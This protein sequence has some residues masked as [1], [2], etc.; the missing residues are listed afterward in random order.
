MNKLANSNVFRDASETINDISLETGLFTLNI[1]VSNI[2]A[3]NGM[4]PSLDVSLRYSSIN[5]KKSAYGNRF[6]ITLSKYD[7]TDK[8]LYLSNGEIYKLKF[9]SLG[10][11]EFEKPEPIDYKIS[12]S[13]NK[14]IL[15]IHKDGLIESFAS[16][17]NAYNTYYV[18]NITTPEG[19]VLSC[20][21]DYETFVNPVL[22][23]IR[24]DN[25][26]L[27]E[28]VRNNET[29]Q[30]IK[31]IDYANR[32]NRILEY[33]NNKLTAVILSE[34]PNQGWDMT[35]E[36]KENMRDWFLTEYSTPNG[37]ITTIVYDF[38]GILSPVS[39]TSNRVGTLDSKT[40]RVKTVTRRQIDTRKLLTK[41][42]TIDMSEE[43]YI[44]EN[45][46][47][48]FRKRKSVSS[49]FLGYNAIANPV[50]QNDDYAV[51]AKG[52]YT[53]SVI[54]LAKF[55][56][57]NPE[58]NSFDEIYITKDSYQ[59]NKFHCLIYIG[60][61]FI[62]L[63]DEKNIDPLTPVNYTSIDEVISYNIDEE[64][65]FSAQVKYYALP[66]KSITTWSSVKDSGEPS[67]RSVTTSTSY[68]DSGN[69]V[70]II[71]VDGAKTT[72]TYY[73]VAGEEGAC[74]PEPNGFV[75]FIKNKTDY[76]A[77][78]EHV[79]PTRKLVNTYLELPARS[80]GTIFGATKFIRKQSE[81]IISVEVPDKNYKKIYISY[82]SDIE[83]PFYGSISNITT[84]EAVTLDDVEKWKTVYTQTYSKQ[85]ISGPGQ[86]LEIETISGFTSADNL[87]VTIGEVH[88]AKSLLLLSSRDNQYNTIYYEYND[89]R[90][91]AIILNKGTEYENIQRITY[92]FG[93]K[94]SSSKLPA[95]RS[96]VT[97]TDAGGNIRRETFD[98]YQNKVLD[99]YAISPK[100]GETPVYNIISENLFTSGLLHRSSVK[101]YNQ[102]DNSVLSTIHQYYR[103]SDWGEIGEYISSQGVSEIYKHDKTTNVEYVQHVQNSY[104]DSF[105]PTKP[106]KSGRIVNQLDNIGNILFVYEFT[107]DD[108]FVSKKTYE[109][110]GLNRVRFYSDELTNENYFSY[111][112]FDRNTKMTR[113][114]SSVIEYEYQSLHTKPVKIFLKLN[115]NDANRMLIG[116][117]TLD[118]LGRVTSSTIGSRKYQYEFDEDSMPYPSTVIKPDGKNIK[119]TYDKHIDN[120]TLS[121]VGDEQT[122][123]TFTYNKTFGWL[124]DRTDH[125]SGLREEFTYNTQGQLTRS[126]L[127]G[128]IESTS[129]EKITNDYVYSLGGLLRE[130]IV[131]SSG[132]KIMKRTVD[133]DTRG[134]LSIFTDDALKSTITYDKLNRHKKVMTEPVVS[135][136][137]ELTTSQEY[138][139]DDF[140]N[141]TLTKFTKNLTENIATLTCTF[142][143]KKRLSTK[144][145]N[146]TDSTGT[147]NSSYTYHYD[148][149]DQLQQTDDNLLSTKT[150]WQYDVLGNI[151]DQTVT[152]ADGKPTSTAS[153]SYA[154][155]DRCQLSH[156]ATDGV[157][158]NLT[159]DSN[160]CLLS[161]G[162]GNT[163]EYDILDRCVKNND[164][165]TKYDAEDKI[166]GNDILFANYQN[167]E[168]T[169]EVQA[170]FLSDKAA[171]SYSMIGHTSQAFHLVV[172][173]RIILSERLM[174]D[175][176]ATVFATMN[177]EAV[178]SILYSSWGSWDYNNESNIP[179]FN[180]E[181][182]IVTNNELLYP[183]GN[184]YRNYRPDIMRFDKPDSESPFGLGGVNYYS[185][186]NN[187]PINNTDPS[188]HA[189]ITAN[190][191][192]YPDD[193]FIAKLLFGIIAAFEFFITGGASS[194]NNVL[195]GFPAKSSSKIVTRWGL[196][197]KSYQT[198]QSR[199]VY[200]K[201]ESGKGKVK[202]KESFTGGINI[203][204]DINRA[205]QKRLNIT[206]HGDVGYIAT[207][208][209]IPTMS[210]TLPSGRSVPLYDFSA[211]YYASDLV[212]TVRHHY[213]GN[214][215]QFSS[216]RLVCCHSADVNDMYPTS[217]AES[218]GKKIGLPT[219]GYK[220]TVDSTSN[221]S[222]VNGI[223]FKVYKTRLELTRD[224]P[225]TIFAA[226]NYKPVFFPLPS[227]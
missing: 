13:N 191:N 112:F 160:G 98:A 208:K 2:S 53:Y 195:K 224:H 141:T 136:S 69:P 67:E 96:R 90:L 95:C 46:E 84:S 164:R 116:S 196:V 222:I 25:G 38:N 41:N 106:G 194:R 97:T 24:D 128:G 55:R 204:T 62:D 108:E 203:F 184:G 74:P 189:S 202:V 81:Q 149:M 200:I 118:G 9:N 66:T 92:E 122:L 33:T 227:P 209:E 15:L 165:I 56:R 6:E 172:N 82:Q 137:G 94:S 65:P 179:G 73:P 125:S 119:Y 123:K 100:L 37:L 58:N 52:A 126:V 148:V 75:R 135:G 36:F 193:P 178:K 138:T 47:T 217:L 4:G 107:A 182:P 140:G 129:S 27:L 144:D 177:G 3:N 225:G 187:D 64:A 77:P 43:T 201:Y 103:Y 102:I 206:G 10:I 150:A 71:G 221:N 72:Y 219:V 99:E 78:S 14:N 124:N 190:T 168:L 171:R 68:D 127:R 110:D 104:S 79:A 143:K 22:F 105:D 32:T 134:R 216:A 181:I 113:P 83:D 157:V 93:S 49:N 76:P 142:D 156:I 91:A 40:P 153:Y 89:T 114:D 19:F 59:Y 45:S 12:I 174:T 211:K 215:S 8:K 197:Q 50:S 131:S 70:E 220:G 111:D 85:L 16:L 167:G 31:F 218:F 183:L 166:R 199:E 63:L 185:Y 120:V 101:D 60:T 87:Q 29:G 1:P 11:P 159:Y 17:K 169:E 42:R 154:D 207:I 213:A 223:D 214:T 109:Y 35:Y 205:G 212:S 210:H 163:A 133:V 30:V 21:W 176:N 5:K 151:I 175:S 39:P 130:S 57:Y 51:H 34:R 147:S 152:G 28:V 44:Y 80:D 88:D 117:R 158:V 226:F 54:K 146:F 180:G 186:A 155:N 162:Q 23:N 192:K 20:E 161:D 198:A 48:T 145:V 18:Q 173:Q 188:G 7:N 61:T 132:I 86:S 26:V 115:E 170:E 139:Y 121:V